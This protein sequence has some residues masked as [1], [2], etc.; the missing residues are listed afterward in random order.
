[1][2]EGLEWRQVVI[3]CVTE[4]I[5]NWD[6]PKTMDNIQAA[7]INP[8]QQTDNKLGPSFNLIKFG[9]TRRIHRWALKFKRER[10]YFGNLRA[11]MSIRILSGRNQIFSSNYRCTFGAAGER[12]VSGHGK[13]T[14]ADPER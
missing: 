2:K 1:M 10:R 8:G 7:D 4:I 9:G 6:L 14:T 5:T 12:F 11:I 13:S 3:T